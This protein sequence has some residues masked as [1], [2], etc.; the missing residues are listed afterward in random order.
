MRQLRYPVLLLALP[1]IGLAQSI[2]GTVVERS[3]QPVPGVVLLLMDSEGQVAA[4]AL[5]DDRGQ[6]R[7]SPGATGSYRIRTY[8]IGYK[9]VLS[10]PVLLKAGDEVEQLLELSSV[11]VSLDTV[12]VA[13]RGSCR[14]FVESGEAVATVWEQARTALTA[15]QLTATSQSI[16][17]TSIK[18]QRTLDQNARRTLQESSVVD[19][20]FVIKVWRSVSADSLRRFGYVHE[21]ADGWKTYHAPDQDVLLSDQFVG[22]HCFRLTNARD[23]SLIGI[24]F[25]P[26]RERSRIPDIRGTLWLDRKSSELRRMDFSYVNTGARGIEDAG[27]DM[28]FARLR[29]G[30]WTIMRWNIRMPVLEMRGFIS[31]GI[32][33]STPLPDLRVREW[34]IS[35]GEL[36]L[37]LRGRDTIWAKPT[38]LVAAAPSPATTAS[39]PPAAAAALPIPPA[40][41][42]VATPAAQPTDTATSLTPVQVSSRRMLSEFEERRT[43][44]AGHF[45]TRAE[46]AKQ[47]ARAL[48]DILT[49]IPGLRIARGEGRA[50][51]TSGRNQVT[52]FSDQRRPGARFDLDP[53]D[54][55]YADV[56]M[57]G[58]MMYGGRNDETR[59][60]ISSLSPAMIEGIEYYASATQ[61][62]PRYNRQGSSC[63]VLL[64]W[65]RS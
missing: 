37:L 12:R 7:L 44:S 45:I 41:P 5:T 46:L 35:G 29:D 56:W 36:S 8:R 51:V 59:F 43:T 3:D 60:D 6:F 53:Q 17:A 1:S 13:S 38:V 11:P 57:N 28:E 25:E 19:S 2:R 49:Q 26:T 9:P 30:T 61:A 63:G 42:P 27:G 20:G 18:H 34:R 39:T 32:P 54:A 24:A 10:A 58:V 40:S 4:R 47:E 65:T 55:C 52:S 15:T 16:R 14:S 23:E 64:I 62:P 33:G 21:G 31:Q 22:D 48:P 50:W